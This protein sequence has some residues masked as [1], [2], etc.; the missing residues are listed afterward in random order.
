MSKEE[1]IQGNEGLM[2]TVQGIM[3]RRDPNQPSSSRAFLMPMEDHPDED[4]DGGD[5]H[6]E[7]E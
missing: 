5:T 2:T 4:E 6:A 1:L 3:Q 7:A